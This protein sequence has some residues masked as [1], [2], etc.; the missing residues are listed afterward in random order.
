MAASQLNLAAR[1]LIRHR[2]RTLVAMSAIAFG[3]VALLMTGG[4]IEWIYWAIREASIQTGLGHVQIVRPGFRKAG[5]A[6]PKAFLLP[7]DAPELAAMRRVPGVEVV[8]ERLLVSGLASTGETT[9]A[10]TGEAV[11]PESDR[12][13]SKALPVDGQNLSTDDPTGVLLGRGLAAA[14]GAKPGDKVTLLVSVPGG[15]IN[16]VEG[17]VRG[18]FATGAKAYDDSAVRMP[19]A[20]GR[21]LLRV[22]GAHLWVVGL[23]ATERTN[24][25]IA[26]VRGSLGTVQFESATWFELSDFYR[27]SVILLSRQ[28]NLVALLIAVIIVLGISNTLTMNV[29]ERTGEIGTMMAVGTRRGRVLR[30]FVLEGLLLGLAGALVGLVLGLLLAAGLSRVGIPMPAPP[31]RTEG[32]SAQILVT[33]PLAVGAFALAVGSTVLASLYPA[34]KASRLPIVDALRHNV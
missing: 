10:F 16:A 20:L 25:A 26:Q 3:V 1:N 21:D 13:I 24:A 33:L 11:D 8:D 9:V 30:L 2:T 28:V 7:Q 12:K 34:L 18:L 22:K 5:A 19:I 23:S 15:G 14:L 4:F 6:N 27:K 29:L 31:G 32:Y 17:L